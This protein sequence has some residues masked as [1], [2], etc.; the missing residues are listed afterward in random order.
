MAG[1][2]TNLDALIALLEV[3]V[4]GPPG[5]Q[6]IV[7]DRKLVTAAGDLV[8]YLALAAVQVNQLADQPLIQPNRP[9]GYVAII[10]TAKLFPAPEPTVSYAL[11]VTGRV[12]TSGGSP[13]VTFDASATPA[14]AAGWSFAANFDTLPKF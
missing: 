1:P 2:I 14:D 4:Q 11:T 8:D 3:V 10:G 5:S 13:V 7:L 6:F 12:D 9:S